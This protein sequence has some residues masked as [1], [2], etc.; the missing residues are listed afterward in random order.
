MN[1]KFNGILSGC[2]LMVCAGLTQAALL[3]SEDFD[4]SGNDLNGQNG[5]TG[6]S[7]SWTV[8]DAGDMA[9][10]SNDGTSVPFMGIFGN[11]SRIVSVSDSGNSASL[12]TTSPSSVAVTAERPLSS[13]IALNADKTYYISMLI[14]KPAGSDAD[15]SFGFQSQGNTE[16][17]RMSWRYTADNK[18]RISS[19]SSAQAT[20][21]TDTSPAA[22]TYASGQAYLLVMKIAAS[23]SGADVFSMKVF[24]DSDLVSEP[25]D[26]D[27]TSSITTSSVLDYFG[28]IQ[29]SGAT[30]AEF[31]RILAGTTFNDVATQARLALVVLRN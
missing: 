15:I 24:S 23:A 21:V 29:N 25:S 1:R 7:G 16:L 5:G 14:Y 20:M 4:Y 13:A 6:W 30:D 26:W 3:A 22:G 2:L 10:L 18:I 9:T 28:F 19:G 11:G 31:D 12:V 17:P 8:L 27:V